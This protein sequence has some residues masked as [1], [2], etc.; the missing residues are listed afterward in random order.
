[1]CN[2]KCCGTCMYHAPECDRW[3]C[4][5]ER[6]EYCGY[7]TEYSDSCEDYEKRERVDC[8]WR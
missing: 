1:M 4:Y 8:P 7:E 5:N 6:S 3:L 2:E